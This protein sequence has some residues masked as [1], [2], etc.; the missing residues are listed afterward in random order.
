MKRIWFKIIL[1]VLAVTGLGVESLLSVKQVEAYE[2]ALAQSGI[3]A[4]VIY[5][6]KINVRSGPSTVHYP[7]IGSLF[8]GDVVPALGVSPGHEWVQIAYPAAPGGAGWV[9][10]IYVSITGGELQVVEAPATGTP[11]VTATIDATLAAQ[12]N[13]EPTSSRIPTFTPPPP[14]TVPHYTE[15]ITPRSGTPPGIFV[16][17]LVFLGVIGLIASFILRR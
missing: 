9:Y 11:E 6:E 14:L 10:A 17:S 4:T 16:A 7:V 5:S 2:D 15:V 12:F 1:G 3:F 8:P 13:F